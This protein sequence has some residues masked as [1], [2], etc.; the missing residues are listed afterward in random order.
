MSLTNEHITH[1]WTQRNL[2]TNPKDAQERY[3][4]RHLFAQLAD[5]Y[6][7]DDC[8]P[9]NSSATWKSRQLRTN[10]GLLPKN[11]KIRIPETNL[12][13]DEGDPHE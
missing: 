11:T 13:V 3:V 6:C 10:S 1:L 7:H 8:G 9:L 12:R 5:K 2:S 4:A